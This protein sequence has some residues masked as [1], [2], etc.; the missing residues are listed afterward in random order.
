MF[1]NFPGYIVGQRQQPGLVK[2]GGL[3]Q[4]RVVASVVVLRLQTEQLTAANA[5]GVEEYDRQS[6]A[7][8]AQ[9]GSCRIVR[10]RVAVAE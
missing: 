8:P 2:L 9:R 5:G 10:Q 3:D 1:I 7:R 4:Q 6:S